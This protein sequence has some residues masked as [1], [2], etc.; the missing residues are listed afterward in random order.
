MASTRGSARLLEHAAQA[1]AKVIAIGDPGQLPSVQAGGW[2]RAIGQRLGAV[3][4]TE[5]MRQRDPAERRALAALHDGIPERYLQWATS[6]RRAEV[7]PEGQ[8]ALTQAVTEWIEGVQQ[9]GLAESVLISRD[10]ETRR[11]LNMLARE[12]QRAT[13]RAGRAARLRSG[14]RRGR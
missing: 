12:H 10:N 7:L 11:A 6:N 8:A 1:G 3:R 13:R 2:L 9:H 4:L 14:E 5:V